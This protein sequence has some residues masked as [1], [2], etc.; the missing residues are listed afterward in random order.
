MALAFAARR[1]VLLE[2]LDELVGHRPG[3]LGRI[4]DGHGAAIV[5]RHVMADTDRE[6]LHRRTRLDLIDDRA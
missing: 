6:K 4:G 2:Q 3:Q 5:A 1:R